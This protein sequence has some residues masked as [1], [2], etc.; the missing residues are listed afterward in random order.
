[1]GKFVHIR[2]HSRLRKTKT[3]RL[4]TKSSLLD[5]KNTRTN[6]PNPKVITHKQGET[7]SNEERGRAGIL[8][9]KEDD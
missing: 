2:F 8:S 1:M 5:A 6:N 9:E 7:I 3:S 4:T